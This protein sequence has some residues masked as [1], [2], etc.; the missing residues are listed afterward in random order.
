MWKLEQYIVVCVQASADNPRTL[1]RDGNGDLQ[2]IIKVLHSLKKMYRDVMVGTRA[3][4]L[5][6]SVLA[7]GDIEVLIDSPYQYKQT[8][9]G[10]WRDELSLGPISASSR[11]VQDL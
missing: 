9:K 5:K 10:A 1:L 7:S 8:Q 6:P 11:R 4:Y 3:K 2:D